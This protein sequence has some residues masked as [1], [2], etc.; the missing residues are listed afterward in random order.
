MTKQENEFLIF[1]LEKSITKRN[2]AHDG[3]Q[4]KKLR[5]K[6]ESYAQQGYTMHTYCEVTEDTPRNKQI[7]KVIALIQEDMKPLEPIPKE[8]ITHFNIDIK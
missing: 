5:K 8:L 3:R 6:I 2:G 1:L 4:G 7:Q